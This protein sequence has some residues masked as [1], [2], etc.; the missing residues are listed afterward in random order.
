MP[1][2][3]MVNCTTC[4][5]EVRAQDTHYSGINGHTCFT[6][7]PIVDIPEGETEVTCCTCGK[8]VPISEAI[9]YKETKLNW[10]VKCTKPVLPCKVCGSTPRRKRTGKIRSMEGLIRYYWYECRCGHRMPDWK[11]TKKTHAR[12]RWNADNAEVYAISRLCYQV[13]Y[14]LEKSRT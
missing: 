7:G 4:K 14:L 12:A 2:R 10:C 9:H 8:R 6:C 13:C 11:D 5:K 3:N 1:I